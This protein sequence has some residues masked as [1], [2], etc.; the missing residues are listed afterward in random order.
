MSQQTALTIDDIENLNFTHRVRK[1]VIEKLTKDGNLPE[2]KTNQSF[3]MKALDGIDRQVLTTVRI[4]SDENKNQ[5]NQEIAAEMARLLSSLTHAK[6]REMAQPTVR[7]LPEDIVVIDPVEGETAIGVQ[8]LTYN[9][10]MD[11]NK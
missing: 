10:F 11:A 9:E 8:D 7:A 1:Q 5:S 2:D 6:M 3:L 4:R